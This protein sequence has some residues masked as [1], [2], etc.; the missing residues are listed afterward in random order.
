MKQNKGRLTAKALL[1]AVSLNLAAGI[2]Y[3]TNLQAKPLDKFRK[4]VTIHNGKV[5]GAMR[6]IGGDDVIFTEPD[7]VKNDGTT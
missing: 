6:Q 2:V 1:A 4:D 3:P 7:T 5:N